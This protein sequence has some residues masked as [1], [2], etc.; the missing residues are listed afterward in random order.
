MQSARTTISVIVPCCN[1]SATIQRRLQA[2]IVSGCHESGIIVADDFSSDDTA[3]LTEQFP[4]DLL[5]GLD[6][7]AGRKT[8]SGHLRHPQRG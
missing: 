4:A 6:R 2:V 5:K 1:N 3:I 8:G 7:P